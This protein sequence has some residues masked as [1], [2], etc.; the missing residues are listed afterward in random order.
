MSHLLDMCHFRGALARESESLLP[1]SRSARRDAADEASEG[2]KKWN[3]AFRWQ[4]SG[5]YGRGVRMNGEALFLSSQSLFPSSVREEPRWMPGSC[6]IV[7]STVSVTPRRPSSQCPVKMK[8]SSASRFEVSRW[9]RFEPQ[10]SLSPL[11][12]RW[13]R[14]RSVTPSPT[15]CSC[16]R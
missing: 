6:P 16:L 13:R 1:L 7:A 5:V 15:W 4:Q 8:A 14:W 12:P 9:I 11:L 2:M 3:A 10:V